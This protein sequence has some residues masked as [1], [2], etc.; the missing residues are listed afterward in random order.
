[1]IAPARLFFSGVHEFTEDQAGGLRPHGHFL[2]LV[3]HRCLPGFKALKK[4]AELPHS[5]ILFPRNC[6]ILIRREKRVVLT[7]APG[8]G[9][10]MFSKGSSHDSAAHRRWEGV[11][12]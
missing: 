1:M 11:L 9:Q 2:A 6:D 12:F 5:S 8:G 7:R 3:N 4:A 10:R